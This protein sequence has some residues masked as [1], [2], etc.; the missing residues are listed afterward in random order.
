[1]LPSQRCVRAATPSTCSMHA[2]VLPFPASALTRGIAW[3]QE[4]NAALTDLLCA[5]EISPKDKGI[6]AEIAKVKRVRESERQKQAA[7]YKRMFS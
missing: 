1:M 7:T 4:H 5:A 6:A 3:L 2:G